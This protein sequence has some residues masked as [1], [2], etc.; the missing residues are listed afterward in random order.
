MCNIRQCS[1]LDHT[2]LGRRQSSI[3]RALVSMNE[4]TLRFFLAGRFSITP[5]EHTLILPINLA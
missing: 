2:I 4:S 1:Q 5:Q 3:L